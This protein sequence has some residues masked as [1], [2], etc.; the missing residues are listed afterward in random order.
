[1]DAAS[2]QLGGIPPF[3]PSLQ[4]PMSIG[5][6]NIVT[7]GGFLA[8]ARSAVSFMPRISTLSLSGFLTDL[9]D[10]RPSALQISTLKRLSSGPPSETCSV[11]EYVFWKNNTIERVKKIRI[12]QHVFNRFDASFFSGHHGIV[13]D[14]E[15]LQWTLLRPYPYE[16]DD[17]DFK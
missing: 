3:P 1:M 8:L 11:T 14:L 17:E 7:T 9:I 15:E 10:G 13:P 2:R 16:A 6:P 12:C 4:D 5:L